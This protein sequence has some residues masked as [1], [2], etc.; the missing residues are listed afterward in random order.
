MIKGAKDNALPDD[1]PFLSPLAKKFLERLLQIDRSLR[2]TAQDALGHPWVTRQKQNRIPLNLADQLS[3]VNHETQLR[4]KLNLVHFLAIQSIWQQSLAA[5]SS[6]NN[7]TSTAES[8]QTAT[9]EP[10]Q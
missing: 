10:S 5:A 9:Q 2:Y 7:V 4:R 6:P 8:D 3:E 1:C